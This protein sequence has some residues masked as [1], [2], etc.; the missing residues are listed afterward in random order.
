MIV[1]AIETKLRCQLEHALLIRQFAYTSL[2]AEHRGEFQRTQYIAGTQFYRCLQTHEAIEI[3]VR[4][5]LVE[6]ARA[7]LRILIEHGVYCAYML[8]V[9][10]TQR[11]DDFVD[12]AKYKRYKDIQLLKRVDE[13]MVRQLVSLEREEELRKEYEPLRPRFKDRNGWCVDGPLYK[14]AALVD[15]KMTG[16]KTER[17]IIFQ[18]LVNSEWRVASSL[19]H[20]TA[21]ALSDQVDPI[22]GGIT[23]E[24]KYV[25]EDAAHVIR[26]ANLVLYLALPLVDNMLGGKNAEEIKVRTATWLQQSAEA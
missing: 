18:W 16:T 10:D 20:G 4:Q 25:P 15:A 7:L 17:D 2:V 13:S 23:L 3:L 5:M 24:Q 9:A 11:A 14:R 22:E 8:T 1:E 12:Y 21:D 26:V 6:D 19:V